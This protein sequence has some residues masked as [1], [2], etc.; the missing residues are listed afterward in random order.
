MLT[1]RWYFPISSLLTWIWWAEFYFTLSQKITW[2]FIYQL[3]DRIYS[4]SQLIHVTGRNP[5][6]GARFWQGAAGLC[7]PGTS[8]P[9]IG[10][11]VPSAWGSLAWWQCPEC[12]LE[13]EARASPYPTGSSILRHWHHRIHLVL[14]SSHAPPE[15]ETLKAQAF[16]RDFAVKKNV[17]MSEVPLD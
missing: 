3:Y 1:Q 15:E 13:L 8:F 11:S 12:G 9:G 10:F 16:L 7:F 4:W 14:P 2:I 6:V 17:E 5:E